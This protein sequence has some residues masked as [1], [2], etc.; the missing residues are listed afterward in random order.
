M[1]LGAFAIL[2]ALALAGCS[3]HHD[4]AKS[5]HGRHDHTDDARHGGVPVML[6]DE[7]YHV[8]FTFGDA[9][10]TLQA[11]IFDA[12]MKDYVRIAAASFAATAKIGEVEH[13][14]VFNAV[15]N[16]ATGETMGSTALFEARVPTLSGRPALTLSVPALTVKTHT[17]INV[18]ASLGAAETKKPNLKQTQ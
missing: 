4:H 15:A 8:E 16:P 5:S 1:S 14:L 11:Y 18:T 12:H 17:Y 7:A 2:L 3:K 13:Q 9:P 10:G 6:G